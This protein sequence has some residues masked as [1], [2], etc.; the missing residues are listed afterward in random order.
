MGMLMRHRQ[1]TLRVLALTL[2]LFLGA[3]CSK[4]PTEQEILE[5]AIEHQRWDEFDDALSSYKM[6]VERFPRSPNV[7]EALYAMGLIYQT[8][9][10][11]TKAVATFKRLGEEYPDHATASSATYIRA[12][13]L[14]RELKDPDGA[15]KAFE[16]LLKRYPDSPT[17]SSAKA[18][19]V[20]LQNMTRKTR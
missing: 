1:D 8:K 14:S 16:E 4:D 3:G 17:V 15:L 20:S 5:K 11:F 10:D 9:K 2:V 19:M 6:L 7:P 12:M 18:E 13:L